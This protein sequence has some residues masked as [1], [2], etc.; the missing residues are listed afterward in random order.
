MVSPV[1]NCSPIR[2]IARST[3]LR[4]SGSPPSTTTR[5]NAARSPTSPCVAT[6]RPVTNSPQVATLTN[7]DELLPKC[8]RQ[9]PVPILS[10]ISASRVAVSGMRNSASARH[11]S[12]TPSFELRENSCSKPWTSPAR[13]DSWPRSRTPR[14]MRSA[15]NPAASSASGMRRACLSRFGSNSVSGDRMCAV[16]AARRGDVSRGGVSP[17]NGCGAGSSLVTFMVLA[18]G[19]PRW[20]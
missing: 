7:N 9:S 14:V 5:S 13:P 15:N 12:A 18:H 8:D 16:M 3:P 1:T 20:P 19:W 2:R 10:R 17:C 11:I 6:S 4:I